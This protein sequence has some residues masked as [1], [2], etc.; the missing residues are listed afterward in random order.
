M[1]SRKLMLVLLVLVACLVPLV[2]STYL[3]II[4]ARIIIYGMLAMSLDLILGYGGMVSL[5]HAAYF[6]TGAYTVGVLALNGV[7]SG[8]VAF[9]AAIAAAAA[10]A[11][12]IG[13][14]SLRTRGVYFIMLTLAFAQMLF[15]LA[16]GQQQ[17]GGDDGM[18]LPH[19]DV[20]AGLDLASP[21]QFYYF[22]L[23]LLVLTTYL[24]HRLV[25]ARFGLILNA[26][27]QNETRLLTV[28]ISTYRYKLVAFVIAGAIA[29]LAGALIANLEAYISPNF[30]DWKVSGDIIMMIVIGGIGTLV[31]PVL[32]AALYIIIEQ[33]V[34]PFTTHWMAILGP[35]LV[36]VALFWRRGVWGLLATAQSPARVRGGPAIAAVNPAPTARPQAET[37]P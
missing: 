24:A 27:R 2:G 35:L 3:S 7:T 23:V 36:L 21:Q 10:V 25:H 33:I 37:G 13:A 29:G 1:P 22:A 32:G 15:Y 17:L 5:G 20:F 28:G 31:G 9:P 26:C 11:L 14:L 18:P 34:T 19:R 12:V 4:G 30:L 8:F 16:V 6:G